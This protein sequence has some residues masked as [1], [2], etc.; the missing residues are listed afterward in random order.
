MSSNWSMKRAPPPTSST[1]LLLHLVEHPSERRLDAQRFLDLVR[2]C[3][4]I[5]PVFQKARTLVITDEFNESWCVR[6]PVHRKTL[7]ILEHRVDTGLRKKS[8]RI[9]GVLI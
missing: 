1:L 6:F 5:F 3:I 2:C 4:R 9:L 8:Y 7:K